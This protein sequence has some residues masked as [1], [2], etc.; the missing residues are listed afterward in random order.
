MNKKRIISILLLGVILLSVISPLFNL[1]ICYAEV[2]EYDIKG[3]EDADDI[4]DFNDRLFAQNAYKIWSVLKTTGMTDEQACGIL[5]V[6]RAESARG[7]APC[8]VESYGDYNIYSCNSEED[9]NKYCEEISSKFE[10][11][12]DALTVK[13]LKDGYSFT[14]GEIATLRSGGTVT[15]TRYYEGKL[16]DMTFYPSYFVDGQGYCGIGIPQFTGGG[17][18][19]LLNWCKEQNCN[20][21]EMDNQLI[22][23]FTVPQSEGGY[24]GGGMYLYDKDKSV[25]EIYME[26]TKGLSLDDCAHWW[27]RNFEGRSDGADGDRLT[28]TH[29]IYDEFKGKKWD[30]RYGAKILDGTG[31]IGAK[32]NNDIH[33][34]GIVHDVAS[35]VMIYPQNSGFILDAD[36]DTKKNMYNKNVAVFRDYVSKKH[37]KTDYQSPQYSLYELFGDDLHWY[38]YL[39]EATYAPR[40]LDRVYSAITQDKL[41]Q[42]SL[43]NDILFYEG[44]NYLSCNVYNNRPMVLTSELVDQGNKDPRVSAMATGYFSGYPY[45]LGSLNMTI[46]KYAVSLT[47]LLLGPEL[48][49]KIKDIIT[50]LE[51]KPIWNEVFKPI[52]MI[53]VGIAMIFFIFS[54]VKKAKN[55][56]VGKGSAR[57]AISRFII[58]VIALGLLGVSFAK[59]TVMNDVIY[60]MV[61]CVDTVFGDVI[62]KFT[63]GDDVIHISM[64]SDD[65]LDVDETKEEKVAMQISAFLWKTAIF[66]PW[67]RGQF[68]G[69]NYD[70]LYTQYAD[71]DDSKKMEQSHE[72]VD[73]EDYS[74]KPFYNSAYYTG[75]VTVPVGNSTEIRN[76]AAYLMSC[77]S[78]YHIDYDVIDTIDNLKM[79]DG[80]IVVTFPNAKTTAYNPT[81]MADTFRIVDAQMN[82]APEEYN[83]EITVDKN[84]ADKAYD[85]MLE[86]EGLP[87]TPDKYKLVINNY[88]NSHK[89]KPKFYSASMAMLFNAALLIFFI[90][91]IW[92]KFKNF[93]LMIIVAV[94]IIYHSIVELFKENSG[95]K[96]Y[97]ESFKKALL[98][99]FIACL[100]CN[101]MLLFYGTFV[102]KGFFK[103]IIYCILCVVVL[104]FSFKDVRDL[105][106]DVR[107]KVQQFRNPRS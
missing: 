32:I 72:L 4:N 16:T 6:M 15:K 5:G 68:G 1:Q 84:W 105:G 85:E 65:V 64:D 82:I 92:G 107:H 24:T 8:V 51:T 66:N 76:W 22:Y 42:L 69:L 7:F 11:D 47:S 96:E 73:L 53:V 14:D 21:Y 36:E 40:M 37:E 60:K 34:K 39:G 77:G 45:T 62:S 28:Y 99:Y 54:L 91:V 13:C 59:P 9:Y 56:A 52:V 2:N 93:V 23:M 86:S 48:L 29:Q 81:L 18:V 106:R 75:D 88:T 67:C 50:D 78:E 79:E 90:P 43:I 80:D 102:D 58:G 98:G 12:H 44:S 17:A 71:V 10:T 25:L 101:I 38:R 46:A 97:G 70:E 35:Q 95:F 57:E 87:A 49:L 30:S 94:Q 74:G 89:L 61:T 63:E 100:K 33:D 26:E 27:A 83:K 31:L 19:A 20:W 55:Y 103:M 41:D 3:T 104:S